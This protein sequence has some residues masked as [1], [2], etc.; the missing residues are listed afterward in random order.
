[1]PLVF[2]DA[3]RSSI[4]ASLQYSSEKI[5]PETYAPTKRKG[6]PCITNCG[7][8]MGVS[9][10]V[11]VTVGTSVGFIVAVTTGNIVGAGGTCIEAQPGRIKLTIITRTPTVCNLEIIFILR[12]SRAHPAAVHVRKILLWYLVAKGV[13]LVPCK[14]SGLLAPRCAAVTGCTLCWAALLSKIRQVWK[15]PPYRFVALKL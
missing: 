14:E 6:F 1:M 7:T 2:A 3:I 10:A 8:G 9:V 11:G 4:A 5:Y 15:F 13:L 12:L